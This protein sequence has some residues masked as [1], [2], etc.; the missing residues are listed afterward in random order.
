MS[1]RG[2]KKYRRI[3]RSNTLRIIG[4]RWRGRLIGFV[5]N[6]GLRP[7]ADR[8]RETLFSWLQSELPGLRCLDLFAGSGALGFEAISR[9]ASNVTMVEIS[10]KVK[11]EL[12]K[13]SKILDAEDCV[14]ILR[15]SAIDYISSNH[16]SY[17]VI[18]LDPPFDSDLLEQTIGAL[19]SAPWLK[20][21]ALIYIE[22]ARST[23]VETWGWDSIREKTTSGT[24][25]R[26]L[27]VA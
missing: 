8:V 23:D 3:R 19:S 5:D 20:S 21:G 13:N 25:Y 15:C 12:E 1:R 24:R 10:Q 17:D 22:S 27:R 2:R 6:E 7:T 9:G 11:S 16:E 4:G 26:L 14:E 18:F